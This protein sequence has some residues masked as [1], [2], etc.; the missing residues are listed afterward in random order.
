MSGRFMDNSILDYDP[1][2]TPEERESKAR[3]KALR[4]IEAFD[5][6]I[7]STGMSVPRVAEAIG[8]DQARFVMLVSRDWPTDWQSI[9]GKLDRWLT[10]Q[11]DR[12]ERESK[13]PMMTPIVESVLGVVDFVKED[14]GIAVIQGDAG[15]GKTE[16][17]R[18]IGLR[19]PQSTHIQIV[20]ARTSMRSVLE[21]IGARYRMGYW[22]R[23]TADVYRQ[24]VDRMRGSTDLLVVDEIH[25]LRGKPQALHCL[26][27]ILKETGIPQVWLGTGDVLKY[28][29]RKNRDN[30]P[31]SQIRSRIT[32]RLDLNQ[33]RDAA[34]VIEADQVR[35]LA[36]AK[37]GLTIDDGGVRELVKIARLDDEG[38]VRL[39]ENV[40]KHAKR[41]V[42]A[43][44]L[45]VADARII[46]ACADRS[47]SV[48]TR[49]RAA[50]PQNDQPGSRA[51]TQD[52][53]GVSPPARSK[54]G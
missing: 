50:T 36:K 3:E 53:G 44:K 27:D 47:L 25:R 37:F 1:D 2:A 8:V 42:A 35:E 19:H 6:F 41:A 29:D 15:I 13:M 7:L 14:G 51:R 9:A 10:E 30:D 46:L 52:A 17:I 34:G 20:E 28:L 23:S 31:W 45:K 16:A 48:R 12:S 33:V 38:G 39:I 32:N 49:G 40:I 43:G 21:D 4:L 11:L 24:V 5:R 54:V 22:S 26:S 18:A